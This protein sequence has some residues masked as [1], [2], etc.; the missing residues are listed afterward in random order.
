MPAIVVNQGGAARASVVVK[1]GGNITLQS[2]TNVDSTDLQDGYT[3]I[4]DI[5]VTFDVDAN[6]IM[7]I[8]AK[9]KTTSI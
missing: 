4:Y 2:L 6:G 3:L 5:V 9:D 1:K 7:K 8:S